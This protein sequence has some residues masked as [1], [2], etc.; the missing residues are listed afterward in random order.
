MLRTVVL[1]AVLI[2]SVITDDMIDY[3]DA[4]A[5]LLA[6]K[7]NNSLLEPPQEL[8]DLIVRELSAIR[9]Q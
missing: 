8:Y 2:V 1:S 6:Q 4:D 5:F 7:W 9:S 3:P